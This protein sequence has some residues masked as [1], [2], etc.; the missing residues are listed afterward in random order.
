MNGRTMGYGNVGE[1]VHFLIHS[2]YRRTIY[3]PTLERVRLVCAPKHYLQGQFWKGEN[4]TRVS[5]S[6]SE[7]F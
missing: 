4:V 3:V 1:L 6:N 7:Y 2:L 5:L